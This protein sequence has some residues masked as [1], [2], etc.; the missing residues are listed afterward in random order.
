MVYKG[1]RIVEPTGRIVKM[2]AIIIA[3]RKRGGMGRERADCDIFMTV[4]FWRHD[5]LFMGWF[6]NKLLKKKIFKFI[7]KFG[8]PIAYSYGIGG[9]DDSKW[10]KKRANESG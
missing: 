6:F 8:P 5:C 9:N 4:C 2:V 1:V 7:S 3:T 10:L